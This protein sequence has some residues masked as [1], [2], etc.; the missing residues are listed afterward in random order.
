MTLG[1]S[2]WVLQ[3]TNAK[4]ELKVLKRFIRKHT[5]GEKGREIVGEQCRQ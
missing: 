5:Y 2:V 3:E 4:I 1:V